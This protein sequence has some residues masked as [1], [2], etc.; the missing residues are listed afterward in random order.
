MLF[1]FQKIKGTGIQAMVLKLICPRLSISFD[2][3]CL[4][5]IMFLKEKLR[6]S[7]VLSLFLIR[8]S[9]K[10]L[11]SLP[12]KKQGVNEGVLFQIFFS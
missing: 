4:G 1:A 10:N 9:L 11:P 6:L 8:L 12:V 7:Q 5:D 2:V 3:V